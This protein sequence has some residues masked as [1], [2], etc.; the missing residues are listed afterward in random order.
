MLFNRFYQPDLDIEALEVI[1]KLE[2]SRSSDMQLPLRWIAIL[3]DRVAA[4][5]ALTSGVHSA[6]DIVKALMAGATVAMTASALISNGIG[7]AGAL[8]EE[9]AQWMNDYEYKS[10][11][12]CAHAQPEMWRTG[13]F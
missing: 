5:F 3:Y 10:L 6:E 13:R 2:L 7:F 12:K 1:P 4:D 8:I 11:T 9:L